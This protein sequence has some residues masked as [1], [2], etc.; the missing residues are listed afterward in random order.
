MLEQASATQVAMKMECER[1][2][3]VIDVAAAMEY[4][5]TFQEGAFDAQP[6]S[7]QA[8]ILRS[9][10][11]KI[12]VGENGV[13]VEVYASRR[14]EQKL[15]SVDLGLVRKTGN[16]GGTVKTGVRTHSNLV[17]PIGLEPTTS[18]MPW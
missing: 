8:E 17:D 11:R 1:T 3:N 10:I 7:A 12:V 6:V 4:L 16:L 5:R 2:S 9:H 13:I 15:G 14:P 18:T